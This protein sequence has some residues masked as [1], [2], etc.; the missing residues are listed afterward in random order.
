M[1]IQFHQAML[2]DMKNWI[3]LDN[4]SSDTIFCNPEYVTSI[5][6]VD[7]QMELHTNGGVLVTK[8]KAT[9]PDWGDAWYNANGMTNIFSYAEMAQRYR[10]T[11]DSAEEDSFTV[12]LPH[13][14]VKFVKNAL[15]LYVYM[16]P[17]RQASV[18]TPQQLLKTQF[19]N[20]VD[21]NKSFYT[22]RQFKRATRA[23]QLF[24]ALGT[25]SIGDLKAVIRM[26][27]IKN[28]P[29][30]TQD[31]DLAQKIFGEDVGALK[32]KST[33][34][35]PV[36][37]V[38]DTIEI[39][40]ELV[41][42]QRAV[43]LCID[44]LSV[45]GLS[46]LTT[47]SRNLYY[48]TAQYVK[49]PT[50]TC[51]REAL[52]H[53][54]RIYRQG[55]FQVV[56]IHSDNEFKPLIEP[57]SQEFGVAMNYAN[58]Q[59]HVPEAERNNRV[60]K[61]RVRATYHRLPYSRLPRLMVQTIVTDSAKK[62]NFF[63]AQHGISPYYSPRMILH[64]RHLDYD[65]HCQIGFGTFVQA[66][67]EPNPSNTTA[68]R[69]LD[70]I[71]LRYNDSHQGGHDLLHLQTNKLI[72]RRK[73]FQLPI[74]PGVIQ[75]VHRLAQQDGQPEGLKI[76]NKTGRLL[77]DQAWI[78]GVDYN[79]EDEFGDSDS[80]YQTDSGDSSG[81]DDDNN[82]HY[83]EMDPNEIAELAEP[84]EYEH[85][86][87]NEE[88]NPS[89][90]KT[91]A[92]EEDDEDVQSQESIEQAQTAIGQLAPVV[93]TRAGRVSRAPQRLS[94]HQS[95]LQAASNQEVEY[96]FENAKIIALVMTEMN[97]GVSVKQV[98]KGH[99]FVQTYSLTKG[100]KKF[101]NAGHNAAFNEIKQLHDRIVFEPIHLSDL[102]DQER[103]RAM[104]SL[105][106]L[107]EKRD[108]RVKGRACANGST[109]RDYMDREDAASPTAATE[110]ILI[111]ALIDAK[112]KRDVMTADIPNAFVQTD[113]EPAEKGKRTI[114]KIRGPLVD[115]LIEIAPEI[116]KPYVSYEKGK[117]LYVK[118]LKAL[119]GMLVSS[120][121]YYKK[122]R[123]DIESIGFVINPYDPCVAN[124]IVDQRQHTLTWHVD[125]LKSSHVDPKVN[126]KFLTWLEKTY[127]S[128]EIG[129][130]K[131]VRGLR[132]DYLAMML[133]FSIAGVLQ[134]DMTLY[135]KSMIADFPVALSGKERFPWNEN[136][137][138]VDDS[139][140]LLDA[141]KS[142]I[143]HTFVM[144]GM[145]L[146]KRGRQDIL[147]GIVFLSTRVTS[148]NH[149]DW[150]KLVKLMNFLKATDNDVPRLYAD[151]TQTIKWYVDA[152]FAVH[153]DYK[154]HTGAT[155]T[156]GSGVLASVSTKQKVNSRSSTEAELV[157][158]DDVIAKILWTKL[159]VEA[160]GHKVQAN[161]IYRDNQSSMKLE[162]NGKSSSGKRTRHFNIKY[163][164]VTDLI[165]RK[166]VQIEFCPTDDMVADYMTKPLTGTKFMLFRRRL[167]NI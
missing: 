61:E 93:T 33:R 107:V 37:V 58:P 46:F 114:M 70:C 9:I 1:H 124:R 115:M 157:A 78:A 73:V 127:A 26:N 96:S 71:Y 28:N 106:F 31:V 143:F 91:E 104:E 21:E 147:P 133:D 151:D 95:H 25:P 164:Y 120:L 119:Y 6:D 128:D 92:D 41:D 141:E 142:K 74:S 154:S 65:K 111:T 54:F 34:R 3:L 17:P 156:F 145:F 16:P 148:P 76:T 43:V 32:G 14:Q 44:G 136:L 90:V 101:G 139:S 88:A 162:L 40:R 165:H 87:E 134:V 138:K 144:K 48:R 2:D 150:A 110:S 64:Q 167:L 10:I 52:Q 117:V 166:E 39:P 140:K 47:I 57:L 149:G 72:T 105:I 129:K 109:Q 81:S 122:F 131:A 80:D 94:L 89:D 18:D 50:V 15:G 38:Q 60:I 108:G 153:P 45:N 4:Q 56:A 75:Q 86:S 27:L 100:L 11:S 77:Y 29:V 67:N 132:H 130:V 85:Q 62:L 69:S 68:S 123:K 121:L 161:I 159:F 98:K 5:R 112:Q 82:D 116:Y 163:F 19:V 146:C 63:P 155:M 12:H 152:A 36:P 103:K 59:E 84:H 13:K 24:H 118:M 7:Q 42:A 8:Q 102:T 30:T 126:D 66:L 113:I 35:K 55:G 51:Y 49:Q 158:V 137:F 22:E 53:V 23:R 20:T 135:V 97:H 160:Q 99:Q 79:E 83:D 125:D